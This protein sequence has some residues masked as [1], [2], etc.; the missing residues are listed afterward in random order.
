MSNRTKFIIEV[1]LSLFVLIIF[2]KLTGI[3]NLY[4]IVNY[5][6]EPTISIN[7]RVLVSNLLNVDIGD[8]IVFNQKVDER[9]AWSFRVVAIENDTFEIKNG[10]VFR[11]GKNF[12]RNLKLVHMYKIPRGL[13]FQL[14]KA[15][16]LINDNYETLIDSV[17]VFIQDDIANLYKLESLRLKDREAFVDKRIKD[18]F[19]NNWNK[20]F[21]GPII[22]PKNKYFVMGDNRDDVL[23]SRYIG[24]IDKKDIIGVVINY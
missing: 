18:E 11:N 21:L 6:N 8:F 9:N 13:Y 12:D 4:R 23:D 19:K 15:K 7:S 5:T 10:S 1:A 16:L 3:L 17:Y 14:S 20:D 24:F 2:L 22:I